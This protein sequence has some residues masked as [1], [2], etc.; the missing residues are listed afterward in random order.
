[1]IQN[2]MLITLN[3][4]IAKIKMAVFLVEYGLQK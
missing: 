1:M 4:A 2:L 3:K